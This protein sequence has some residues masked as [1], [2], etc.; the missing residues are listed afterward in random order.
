MEV[1]IRLMKWSA[2]NEMS[3][4]LGYRCWRVDVRENIPS[5]GVRLVDEERRRSSQ[6]FPATQISHNSPLALRQCPT[7]LGLPGKWLLDQCLCAGVNSRVCMH[8]FR[9]ILKMDQHVTLTIHVVWRLLNNA[10][11]FSFTWYWSQRDGVKDRRPFHQE[12]SCGWGKD[13]SRPHW[14]FLVL[15]V[16]FS[17]L[18][19]M[20]GCQKGHH[21]H[22]N[23]I[24]LIAEVVFLNRWR[25]IWGGTGWPRF[26]WKNG[27]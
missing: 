1:L 2:D 25:R 4:F 21:T 15:S 5:L 10:K 18:T 13:E 23:P 12:S 8:T 9:F 24:A 22:K 16:P 6:W 3:V 27:H 26:T 20:V 17:A 7:C 11:L 14:L 19:L